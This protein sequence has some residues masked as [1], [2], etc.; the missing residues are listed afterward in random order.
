MLFYLHLFIKRIYS[1]SDDLLFIYCF[2]SFKNSD[3]S[4]E[5]EV[6]ANPVSAPI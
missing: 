4:N 1:F 5:F 2:F 6:L 3:I